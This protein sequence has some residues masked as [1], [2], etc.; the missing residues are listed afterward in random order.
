MPERSEAVATEGVLLPRLRRPGWRRAI[1]TREASIV[2]V[3][4]VLGTVLSIAYPQF[5]TLDNVNNILLAVAQVAIVGVGMTM[6]IVTGGIDVSVGSALAV[7]AV[8]VGQQVQ[9]GAGVPG[10]I[11]VGVAVGTAIGLVNGLLIAFGRVH[12][13]IITFGMLNI[14]RVVSFKVTGGRWLSG[15]PDTLGYFGSGRLAGL[16]FAWWIAMALAAVATYYLRCRPTG[17]HL[18]ALGGNAETARLAGVSVLKRTIFVY[19]I[20][21]TLV[22]VASIVF[23][24]GTGVVQTNV[25]V[26]FELDV[27]AAVVIGGTSI[28]GGK[29]T[30]IGTLLGALL[31]GTI[32]NALVIVNLSALYTGLILGALI[33]ATVALDLLRRRRVEQ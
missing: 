25:G 5:R 15:L 13:I 30:V 27:I 18:Y 14:L 6:V 11:A 22:G 12:S 7:C 21:G 20:T 29:G 2:A 23:V 8:V 33:L 28:L 31:V 17:R 24:G 1:E 19:T 4:L 10:A 9:D 26:G 16:P 3:L 32:R